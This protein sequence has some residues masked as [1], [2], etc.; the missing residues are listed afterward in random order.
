M[1]PDSPPDPRLDVP[2][3][4]PFSFKRDGRL[5]LVPALHGVWIGYADQRDALLALAEMN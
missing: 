4:H 3:S 1:K 2:V 5:W